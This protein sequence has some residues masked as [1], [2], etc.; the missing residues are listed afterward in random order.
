MKTES[1]LNELL[2]RNN[3]ETVDVVDSFLWVFDRMPKRMKLIVDLK[4]SNFTDDE[5]ASM[6]DIGKKE[7]QKRLRQAKDRVIRSMKCTYIEDID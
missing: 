6:L 1:L 4:I 2:G 7:V 3:W 5:I